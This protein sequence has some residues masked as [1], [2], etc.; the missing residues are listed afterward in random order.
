MQ[1]SVV[2]P[3]FNEEE[4]LPELTA[5]IQRVMLDN[6]FTYEILLVDDGSKDNS[7]E[8]IEKLAL[9]NH[10]IKGILFKKNYAR[11]SR[12]RASA[13]TSRSCSRRRR[14]CWQRRLVRRS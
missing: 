11:P 6:F 8:V 2:V 10:H 12:A 4:S 5:W 1:I 3:L 9:E 14:H 7:W 13:S